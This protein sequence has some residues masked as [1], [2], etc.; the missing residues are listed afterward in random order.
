MKQRLAGSELSK[1]LGL[2]LK[3]F[4]FP[5]WNFMIQITTK[6]PL[7]SPRP[8]SSCAKSM[9]AAEPFPSLS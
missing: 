5:S 2:M 8:L 9:A 7:V 4:E 6:S 1:L 3:V